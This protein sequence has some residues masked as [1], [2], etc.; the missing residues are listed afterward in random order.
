MPAG[1]PS[2][3]P[4]G[5]PSTGPAGTPSS[6][7]AGTPSSGPAGTTSSSPAGIHSTD[8]AG[9]HSTGPAGTLN[10]S[11]QTWV[12]SELS[13]QDLDQTYEKNRIRPS[14]YNQDLSFYLNLDPDATKTSGSE[15]SV[16]KTIFIY[17]LEGA[18]NPLR[19]PFQE[20]SSLNI[21]LYIYIY[22]YIYYSSSIGRIRINFA[23]KVISKLRIKIALVP[24]TLRYT[25]CISKYEW[26]TFSGIAWNTLL[27]NP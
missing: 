1:T 2:S 12:G 11:P 26:L 27:W 3:G 14:K 24:W 18:I 16:K 25:L 9:I 17:S 20:E 8:P 6:G 4:A 22:V 21:L 13:C 7:P 19:L 5:T 15:N 23:F 10:S